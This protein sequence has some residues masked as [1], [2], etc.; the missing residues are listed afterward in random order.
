MRDMARICATFVFVAAMVGAGA[1]GAQGEARVAQP[2]G[3]TAAPE[4]G[5]VEL[6]RP[7][8][9]RIEV[10]HGAGERFDLPDPL[11]LGPFSL[12]GVEVDRTPGDGEVIT[13]FS[14]ALAVFH[15]LGEV[16]LPELALL[17]SD[18]AG[19][20]RPLRIPGATVSIREVGEGEELV[21]PPAP[22]PFEAFAWA[23]VVWV[24]VAL[25]LLLAGGWLTWRWRLRS[26]VAPAPIPP[27][28][29]ALRELEAVAA[30][31]KE[32]YGPAAL[33]A[34][35]FR[36]SEILRGYLAATHGIGATEMT[37]EELLTEVERQ[38]IPGLAPAALAAWL[39]RGDLVRFASGATGLQ[40]LHGDIEEAMALIEGMEKARLER[41]EE[42]A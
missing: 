5:A 25:L 2:H 28:A 22:L 40:Q 37:T 26:A 17:A 35:T 14:L 11:E 13:T 3:F 20:L 24:G 30:A 36:L 42:V 19:P 34:L 8:H 16:A 31:S 38:R 6:G 41:K 12:L 1:V 4:P 23:R 15:A 7:F 27:F 18:G 21:S 33:R 32:A 29:Q 9:Y 10:R 39:R